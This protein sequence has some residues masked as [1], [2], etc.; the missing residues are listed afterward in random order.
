MNA[1]FSSAEPVLRALNNHR[2][3]SKSNAEN[4]DV[5][6]KHKIVAS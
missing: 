1:R 2:L 6:V 3:T 5:D 4:F